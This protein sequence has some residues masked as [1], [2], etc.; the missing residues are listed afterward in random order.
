MNYRC[1]GG[2]GEGTVRECGMDLCTSL[3]LK[4]IINKDLLYG[5]GNSAQCYA[6]AWKGEEFGENGYVYM[7]G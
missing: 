5:R 4:E 6:A 7:Y 2:A 3:Y 1:R